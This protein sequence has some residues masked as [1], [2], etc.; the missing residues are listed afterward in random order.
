[1][2]INSAVVGLTGAIAPN[3]GVCTLGTLTSLPIPPGITFSPLQLLFI[4]GSLGA[5]LALAIRG[6]WDWI[7]IITHLV[8]RGKETGWRTE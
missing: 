2:A 3:L 1:M 8:V 5:F 6:S 4:L 7:C